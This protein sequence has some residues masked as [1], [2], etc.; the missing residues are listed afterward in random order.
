L[1]G[2]IALLPAESKTVEL[3]LKSNTNLQSNISLS[4]D[5]NSNVRLSF[6]PNK[7]YVPSFGISS[8]LIHVRAMDNATAHPYTLPIKANLSFPIAVTNWLTGD[9]LTNRGTK[10]I[11]Q[12]ANFTVLVRPPLTLSEEINGVWSAWGTPISGIVSLIAVI[13][14][15]VGGWFLKNFRSKK[16]KQRIQNKHRNFNDGW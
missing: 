14:G 13:L 8:S 6:E 2:S 15:G 12:E 10:A 4:T 1:P 9:I 3:Q 16:N 11:I 7:L 5:P